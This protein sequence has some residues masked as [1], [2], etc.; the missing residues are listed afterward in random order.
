MTFATDRLVLPRTPEWL[1]YLNQRLPG[2]THHA[3]DD[4]FTDGTVDS[5]W[6]TVA[7]SGTVSPTEGRGQMSIGF[8]SQASADFGGILKSMGSLT[9]PITIETSMTML[10]ENSQFPMVGLAFSDGVVAASNSFTTRWYPKNSLIGIQSGT[11]TNLEGSSTAE[12]A[13]IKISR[14][15]HRLIWTT[16]NTFAASYSPDGVTW[17]RASLAATY[18]KTMTPTHFGLMTSAWGGGT[19][20][21]VAL[22]DYFRVYESD[23]SS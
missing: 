2:E 18:S 13:F 15:Y 19:D 11:L 22:F 10:G 7:I 23:L 12:L 8:H 6:N 16:S 20:V 14:L 21:M 9:A 17:T 1:G 4:F 3:D 5:A